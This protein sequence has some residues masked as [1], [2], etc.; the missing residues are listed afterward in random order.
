MKKYK[1]IL[2]DSRMYGNFFFLGTSDLYFK[3]LFIFYFLFCKVA[4]S[5]SKPSYNPSPVVAQH[6]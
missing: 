1:N 4:D 2:E 6:A 3:H 5:Q